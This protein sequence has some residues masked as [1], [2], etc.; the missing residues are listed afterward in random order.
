MFLGVTCKRPH[1]KISNTLFSVYEIIQVHI[2]PW[3][4]RNSW[5]PITAN[6]NSVIFR[7]VAFLFWEECVSLEHGDIFHLA[8]NS[9]TYIPAQKN[10]NLW[11]MKIPH[12]TLE[13]GTGMSPPLISSLSNI[14]LPGR[15]QISCTGPKF[16]DLHSCP[17]EW[18]PLK[19]LKIPHKTLE[20][21]TGMSPP[22]ISSLNNILLPGRLQISCT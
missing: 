11:K 15:L 10:G 20:L 14:L 1:W 8:Q 12:K 16:T 4:S 5:N 3:F 7:N 22:L 17:K 18:E 2:F 6:V 9:L 21:R 19:N 13:L